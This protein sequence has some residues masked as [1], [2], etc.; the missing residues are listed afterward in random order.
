VFDASTRRPGSARTAP[1]S[2]ATSSRRLGWWS[3][4]LVAGLFTLGWAA[5]RFGVLVVF[6]IVG[7]WL[8]F[9]LMLVL[10]AVAGIQGA[11][12]R[13]RL[14]RGGAAALSEYERYQSVA[15]SAWYP[16]VSTRRTARA[17]APAPVEALRAQRPLAAEDPLPAEEKSADAVVD[18]RC[19]RLRAAGYLDEEAA[20]L[21]ARPDVDVHLAERLLAQGCPRELA[22]R[23]LR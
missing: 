11:R 16:P 5:A 14:R 18:W 22:L 19:E 15:A 6:A 7:A 10:M 2:R 3:A 17:A 8:P 20:E 1:P 13:R 21:A 9:A 23:I 12:A 4:A